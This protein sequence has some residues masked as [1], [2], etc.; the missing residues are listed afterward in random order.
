MK[1]RIAQIALVVDDYDKAIEFYTKKLHFTL[2]EDSILSEPT[3]SKG[4]QAVVITD[5]VMQSSPIWSAGSVRTSSV[6]RSEGCSH[7]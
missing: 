2:I 1:Q 5:V 6:P 7:H 3:R 4:L